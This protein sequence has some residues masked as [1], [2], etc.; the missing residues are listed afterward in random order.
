MLDPVGTPEKRGLEGCAAKPVDQ[1]QPAGRVRVPEETRFICGNEVA[2][3]M[4]NHTPA[5][6]RVFRSIET[7]RFEPDGAVLIRTFYVVPPASDATLGPLFQT[8]LP[9]AD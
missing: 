2:W 4:E 6:G 8:Y 5:N 1:L 7:F 9:E 3:V